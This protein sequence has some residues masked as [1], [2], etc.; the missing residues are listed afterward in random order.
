[1]A[2]NTWHPAT[3]EMLGAHQEMQVERLGSWGCDTRSNSRLEKAWRV[4][5]RL[6]LLDLRRL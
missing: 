4:I 5:G 3:A 2:T 1:M 6:A